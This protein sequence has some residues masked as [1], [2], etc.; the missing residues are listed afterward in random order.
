[1]DSAYHDLLINPKIGTWCYIDEEEHKIC[2][3]LKRGTTFCSLKD[4]L[5]LL[6]CIEK[7]KGIL[8]HLYRLGMLEVDGET[9]IDQKIYTK[10]PLFHRQ[11][12]IEL[13]LTQKCNLACKYCF[14]N[15]KNKGKQEM[16][17][18]IGFKAIDKAFQLPVED[19]ILKFGGGEPFL[20]FATISKLVSYAEDCARKTHKRLRIQATTNGTL[21][22][23]EVIAFIKDHQLQLNVS[24]DGPKD[25][26]DKT[27]YFA[28]GESAYK[29]T[30]YGIDKLKESGIRFRIISL[31][32]GYNYDKT[33]EI[34]RHFA[35]LDVHS[36]RFNPVFH[37]GRALHEWDEVG[38]TP[39]EYFSF[40]QNVLKYMADGLFLEEDNLQEMLRNLALRTRQFR[41]MRSPCGAGYD[42]IAIDFRGNIYPCALYLVSAKEL[43][44]GNI[45]DI[46][47]LEW[48][49]LSNSLV[50]DMANRIVDNIDECRSCLWRHFC[51]AGCSLEPYIQ[52]RTLNRPTWLCSYYKEMYP[53]LL[54]YV[55]KNYNVVKRMVPEVLLCENNSEVIGT[56]V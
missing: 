38:I 47:S 3:S 6:L 49:F 32:N 19:L 11:Y 8:T 29:E 50:R 44:M 31:I 20:R 2:Q 4:N 48:C 55:V 37:T 39:E 52:Y 22:K 27:R 1:M 41:C 18:H 9:G 21:L 53:Y 28:K 7:L 43:C 40:M 5:S 13:L 26:N 24:L 34:L 10:G 25:I 12:V 56:K 46:E 51:E 54:D 23:D 17:L 36:V 33:E 45:N 15:A 30:L 16:P 42:H 35:T 14:G